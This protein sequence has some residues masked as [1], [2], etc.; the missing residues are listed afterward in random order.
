MKLIKLAVENIR[1]FGQREIIDFNDDFTILI[2]PNAGGKSN[3]LD[4]ITVG[5][6]QFFLKPWGVIADS[7]AT[8]PFVRFGSEEAFA[9]FRSELS[10]FADATGPST[11]E[12]HWKLYD[13]DIANIKKIAQSFDELRESAT[14]IRNGPENLDV[15]KSVK[16]EDFVAGDV[17]SY[18]I[19]DGNVQSL[20]GEKGTQFRHFLQHFNKLKHVTKETSDLTTPFVHFSAYR[21]VGALRM[22]LAG[23]SRWNFDLAY[24]RTTSRQ[25]SSLIDLATF[26]FGSKRRHLESTATEKGFGKAFREDPEVVQVTDTLR[27][28]G[29]EWDVVLREESNNTYEITLTKDTQTF[30]LA[31]ASSGEK[32]IINFVLG[33]FALNVR[34]GLV[35]VDEPELHLHPKWQRALYGV[36]EELHDITK[37]QFVF[38]T[39]SAAF[40][41]PRTV[42]KLK[43]V[44]RINKQSKVIPLASTLTG[45]KRDMLQIINSHNNE[46]LFFADKVVLV[47][48]IQ[49]RLIFERIIA[50]LRKEKSG[51]EMPATVIIEVLEVY[52]KGNLSKYRELLE[53][54]EVASFIIADR[55]Y[56]KELGNADVRAL[57][58]EDFGKVARK[59]LANPK[60][61][62]RASLTAEIDKAISTG[63][64]AELQKTW[65]HIIDRQSTFKE[66]LTDEDKALLER[67]VTEQAAAHTF[68]LQ[69]GAL[70]AYLPSGSTSLEGTIELVSAAD[71]DGRMEAKSTEYEELKKICRAVI[72]A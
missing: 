65:K 33:I 44:A 57:F 47:E 55:D 20:S 66:Q 6:R 25:T 28:L 38:A 61:G 13:Q 34:N 8:G 49:D 3:L 32:E 39:H 23:Q 9:N 22:S 54:M 48:G 37:N 26:H 2:G 14:Y 35:V 7:D 53:S 15:F 19:K 58:V 71:F 63:D 31:S 30:D 56:A 59:T 52:G 27:K 69:E 5:V 36:F 41:T 12:F 72:S 50:D 67:F 64:I 43:R 42:G 60:S 29:Y 4:V 62:D 46:K 40:V 51:P 11:M 16:P 70:E 68:I 24:A 21:S 45:K 17:M 18:E 10:K 1:S